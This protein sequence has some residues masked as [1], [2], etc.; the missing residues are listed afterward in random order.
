[1]DLHHIPC[2]N[3]AANS[4][5]KGRNIVRTDL[6]YTYIHIYIYMQ[7]CLEWNESRRFYFVHNLLFRIFQW[8]VADV[9]VQP[10]SSVHIGLSK[11]S[12]LLPSTRIMQQG[13]ILWTEHVFLLLWY[14]QKRCLI[15]LFNE[16]PIKC[17]ATSAAFLTCSFSYE[18]VFIKI[19]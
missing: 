16:T 18:S 15:N 9:F 4:F 7:L 11:G 8:N 10:F 2:Y 17:Q 6:N 14:M 12:C 13:H 5:S 3:Q 1:M 19:L